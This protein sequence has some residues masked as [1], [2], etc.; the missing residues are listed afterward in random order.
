M[1]IPKLTIEQ[2]NELSGKLKVGK[3]FVYKGKTYIVDSKSVEQ[4]GYNFIL[5]Q[6]P[7]DGKKYSL[8][9]LRSENSLYFLE[10]GKMAQLINYSDIKILENI[11]GRKKSRRNNRNKKSRKNR[12]SRKY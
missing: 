5:K 11:G 6:I 4:W 2:W 1:S 12:K 7:D 3:S 8:S 10:M 9:M